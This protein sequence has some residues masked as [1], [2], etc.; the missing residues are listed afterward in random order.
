MS[1][2]EEA[3][4]KTNAQQRK[5]ENMVYN[6]FLKVQNGGVLN[7]SYENNNKNN[8]KKAMDIKMEET[9]FPIQKKPLSDFL[10]QKAAMDEVD[11][12]TRKFVKMVRIVRDIQ[13]D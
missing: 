11:K 7:Q 8:E 12:E 1:V 6:N 9:E 5:F 13:E 2:R 3:D 4:N 10:M